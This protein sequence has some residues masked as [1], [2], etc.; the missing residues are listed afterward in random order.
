[1]KKYIKN[2]IWE[3][4]FR[5]DMFI[6]E[7][8]K[9]IRRNGLTIITG[10]PDSPITKIGADEWNDIVYYIEDLEKR[11]EDLEQRVGRDE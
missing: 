7:T 10:A 11:I 3:K 4:P 2:L 6:P 5:A 8:H 9:K 1:M